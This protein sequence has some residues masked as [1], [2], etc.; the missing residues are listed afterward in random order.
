[1]IYTNEKFTMAI[2]TPPYA[3]VL[4]TSS[5]PPAL[6]NDPMILARV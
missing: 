3:Q 1:V 6:S 2:K 4:V 5:A